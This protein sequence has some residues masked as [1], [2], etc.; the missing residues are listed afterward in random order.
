MKIK[1]SIILTCFIG[2]IILFFPIISRGAVCQGNCVPDGC[3]KKCPAGCTSTQDPDCGCQDYNSCCG[4]GCDGLSDNDC[5]PLAC[6]PYNQC[7]VSKGA[8]WYCNGVGRLVENSGECGCRNDWVPSPDGTYCCDNQCNGVCSKSG[9]TA[10]KDPDCGS[11][12]CCGNHICDAGENHASCSADCLACVE[13]WS[14]A[15]WSTCVGGNQTQFCTD[16]NTCGTAVNKPGT[17]RPCDST[18]PVVTFTLPPPSTASSLTVFFTITATDNVRVTGYLI[19][20][21]PTTPLASA[22][23]WTETAPTSYTFAAAGSKILYAWARDAA[24]N[25]SAGIR[26]DV[27]IALPIV[28]TTAPLVTSFTA[29][30]NQSLVTADY[31]VTDNFAL[32]RVELWRAAYD[33]VSCGETVKTGC[34]WSQIKAKDITGVSQSGNFTD[35]PAIGSYWYGIHA[36]DQVGNEGKESN[37]IKLTIAA[38]CVPDS[39]AT[40]CSNLGKNCG[41]VIHNDNCGAS[42]NVAD[43]SLG[44]GC[45]LPKIC[46]I[47]NVC[48][49]TPESDATFCSNKCGSVTAD[50]NCGMKRNDI[51]C[52]QCALPKTC[53]ANNLC[54][55]SPVCPL[56]SEVCA[57]ITDTRAD[58]CNGSCSVIGVKTGCP[59]LVVLNPAVDDEI[60]IAGDSLTFRVFINP[61]ISAKIV[62]INK[63]MQIIVRRLKVGARSK[64]GMSYD[65]SQVF[66]A[67]L[68]DDG[69]HGDGAKGDNVWGATWEPIEEPT[70]SGSTDSFAYH[71]A[72]IL[73]DGQNPSSI[74]RWLKIASKP[75]CIAVLNQGETTNGDP[76]QRI[77]VVYLSADDGDPDHLKADSDFAA[78]ALDFKNRLLKTEP[79]LDKKDKMNFWRVSTPMTCVVGQKID[80][81]NNTQF[82]IKYIYNAGCDRCIEC[83]AATVKSY[84]MGCQPD[85]VDVIV[86]TVKYSGQTRAG[87]SASWNGKFH[88]EGEGKTGPGVGVHEFGHEFGKLFDEY[89]YPVTKAN[90]DGDININ[91]DK[92]GDGV[93]NAKDKVDVCNG[94]TLNPKDYCIGSAQDWMLACN[95]FPTKS[96]ASCPVDPIKVLPYINQLALSRNC[97]TTYTFTNSICGALLGGTCEGCLFADWW[98]PVYYQTMMF[99]QK[100]PFN[101]YNKDRFNKMFELLLK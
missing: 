97:N 77:D 92:V 53:G 47:D 85:S 1:Y 96:G 56:P 82:E 75:A 2:I 69:S 66:Y 31:T 9:C 4:I 33:A 62:I 21:S 8:P 3:N 44:A 65:D 12:G 27:T 14:C 61:S 84:A 72:Y 94:V 54:A 18:P 24:S 95:G 52:G 6:T 79:F 25:V 90:Y 91:G 70:A 63:G 30:A 34:A 76:S 28:D 78:D 57:G 45:A 15:A 41:R 5:P 11:A 55:C 42:R 74:L 35:S 51:S 89:Y 68:Y 88:P 20:E 60:L 23:G 50:D 36:I 16:A 26:R 71:Y 101:A 80:T 38:A 73:G 29:A 39:D 40:F 7:S 58:G 100:G 10:A 87:Y 13:D 49:C 59:D 83:N 48:A 67:T 19:T 22:A 64:T 98:R 17:E 99:D 43:C 86:N 81:I 93:I 46:G 32:Q 37:I